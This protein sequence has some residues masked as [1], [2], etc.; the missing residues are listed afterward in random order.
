MYVFN[1]LKPTIN[2]SDT[3]ETVGSLPHTC[4]PGGLLVA[5]CLPASSTSREGD[6]PQVKAGKEAKKSSRPV[7][8]I[9]LPPV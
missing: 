5:A 3:G 4:P 6:G 7:G 9:S 8:V 2:D 1:K